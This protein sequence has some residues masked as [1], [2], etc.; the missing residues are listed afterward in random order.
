MP[1]SDQLKIWEQLKLVQ[2]AF[3]FTDEGCVNFANYCI[4]NLIKGNPTINR[5][6]VDMVL[7]LFHGPRYRMIMAQRGQAKTTITAIYAVFRLIHDPSLRILIFSAGGKMS[8]EIA[9]W[10]IQ[11]IHGLDILT[12]LQA[13]RNEGDRASVEGYDVNW[14]LK[15]ANK[16]PSVKCLGVDSNAQGSRADVLIADDIES[17]KNARTVGGRELLEELTKEFESICAEGDIIYLGT[18]QT[19]E[20]IYNN[21]PSR[22]YQIR[23]WTGRYPTDSEIENYGDYLSPMLVEDTKKNP[24]LKTG[25]G[26]AGNQ[27]QPTCPTMFDDE[28]LTSKQISMGNAKFQL[29][30]MLNT[31]LSDADRYPLKL[32]NLIVADF[33]TKQGPCLPVWSQDSNNIYKESTGISNKRE[34]QMFWAVKKKYEYADFHRSVMHIDPAGLGKNGDETGYSIIK[35]I[36]S[37]IYIV[38]AT[39]IEGGYAEETLM[40]LVEAA[41]RNDVKQVLIEKNFGN[42]AHSAMLKPLFAKHH[43]VTIEEVWESGQKELRIID[44]IEPVLSRHQ[45]VISPQVIKQDLQHIQRYPVA[46]QMTYSLLYQMA[47]ITRDKGCL[48]HDDILDSLASAIRYF[49]DSIDFDTAAVV[50]REQASKQEQFFDEWRNRSKNNRMTYSPSA[51]KGCNRFH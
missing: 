20:S 49:T 35:L 34:H 17:M 33:D 16:S 2:E 15:G 6:Q 13:D 21:L 45:L 41:K 48:R 40:K 39:G 22:G 47:F 42:G 29:Q 4:M 19:S 10:V 12:C 32:N 38:E 46:T 31:T 28:N 11:I 37:T 5:V 3:P 43:P 23:I 1:L 50:A 18:P 9:S 30:Y 8:K 26:L 24:K 27:G 44:V 51:R 14:V 25:G 7:W 36:G